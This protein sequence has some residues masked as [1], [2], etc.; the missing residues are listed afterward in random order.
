[1][2][3]DP[4]HAPRDNNAKDGDRKLGF[5]GMKLSSLFSGRASEIG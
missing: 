5:V 1:M 2:T 3:K 4:C